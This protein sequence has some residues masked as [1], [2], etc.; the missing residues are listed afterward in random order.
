MYIVLV[1]FCLFNVLTNATFIYIHVK[2]LFI[3]FKNILLISCRNEFH[4]LIIC[5]Y[6]K[7]YLS[8]LL[9]QL[10]ALF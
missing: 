3:F 6:L 8:D 1:T 7:L 10:P 4:G 9:K 5:T 2:S